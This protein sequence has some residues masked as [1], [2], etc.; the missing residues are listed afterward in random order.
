MQLLGE[1]L[2]IDLLALYNSGTTSSTSRLLGK[3]V[4]FAAATALW[5]FIS[6]AVN[7]AAFFN[8]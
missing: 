7:S 8:D 5:F 6:V 3:C 2:T 4:V 1:V